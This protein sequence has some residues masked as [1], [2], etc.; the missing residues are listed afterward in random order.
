MIRREE[1][2][3]NRERVCAWASPHALPDRQDKC[4]A[5]RLT[6]L[7]S[8]GGY[9]DDNDN[10]GEVRRRPSNLGGSRERA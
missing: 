3:T 9:V 8:D 7:P 10:A 5:R 1:R 2:E 4:D 6:D